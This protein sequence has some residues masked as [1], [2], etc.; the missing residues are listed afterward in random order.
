MMT[1]IVNNIIKYII[2]IYRYKF[3]FISILTIEIQIYNNSKY[4]RN[5]NIY[6]ITKCQNIQLTQ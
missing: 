5:R 6:F 2:K 3:S 4:C 1:Y